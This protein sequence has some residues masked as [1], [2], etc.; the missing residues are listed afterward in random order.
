MVPY[1]CVD[2]IAPS[3]KRPD[4]G[5]KWSTSIL[6]I[7]SELEG[8]EGNR[9]VPLRVEVC[10]KKNS[11]L[12]SFSSR[13]RAC[14]C[15]FVVDEWM[16]FWLLRPTDSTPRYT[17]IVSI[18]NLSIRSAID[19]SFP[20]CF[21]YSTFAFINPPLSFCFVLQFFYFPRFRDVV[22]IHLVNWGF[23]CYTPQVL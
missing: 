3:V 9:Q 4:P 8:R 16:S 14:I 10:A 15:D 21:V 22:D 2:D 18:V 5:E 20:L 19:S 6:R 12:P 7:S 1:C 13:S 11:F 23:L 17:F